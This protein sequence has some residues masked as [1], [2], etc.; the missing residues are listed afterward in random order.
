MKKLILLFLFFPIFIYSYNANEEFTRANE[1]YNSGQYQDA[2]KIYETLLDSGYKNPTIYYNLGNAYYR[3]EKIPL[4]I[5]NYERARK[6]SPLNEDINFNLKLANLKIV[7]KFE[8]VPKLFFI[9]WY[10]TLLEIGNS[11]SWAIVFIVFIWLTIL[12]LFLTFWTK[13]HFDI[14]KR[15]FILSILFFILSIISIFLTFRTYYKEKYDKH[16]IIFSPSVYVKSSPDEN[17]TDLF[18]LHEG[19]KVQLLDNINEWY[20]VK[21]Q[22]G[23][24]GWIQKSNFE[25]I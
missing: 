23:N 11:D 15:I 7:D 6:L 9:E 5:L 20:E 18:I 10:D 19:T 8:P 3:L 12:S 13:F 22:N 2:A 21:V 1:L 14:K 24:V 25:E 16:A 17:A 4:A